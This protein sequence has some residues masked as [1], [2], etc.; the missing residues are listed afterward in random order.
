MPELKNDN[1]WDASAD[2]RGVMWGLL[3]MSL[4]F[5]MLQQQRLEAR[6]L[7]YAAGSNIE[8]PQVS[9]GLSQ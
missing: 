3:E 8:Y 4:T 1:S 6:M 9:A 7:W 2:A 5:S